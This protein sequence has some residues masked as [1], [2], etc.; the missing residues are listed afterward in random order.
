MFENEQYP[1]LWEV[2]ERTILESATGRIIF[3]VD[4]LDECAQESI[5]P[6][7]RSIKT[8]FNA[9]HGET[10][11]EK[12]KLAITS[13]H[14]PQTLIERLSDVACIEVSLDNNPES[15]RD[16]ERFIATN[17]D[18]LSLRKSLSEELRLQVEKELQKGA[19]GTFLWVGLMMKQLEAKQRIEM[20][21]AL[22]KLPS[23]LDSLYE[24]LLLQIQDANKPDAVAVVEYVSFV[25]ARLSFSELGYLIGQENVAGLTLDEVIADKIKFCEGLIEYDQDYIYPVHSSL[26]DYLAN[27]NTTQLSSFRMLGASTHT[28][29]VNICLS[30]IEEAMESEHIV[31]TYSKFVALSNE[32]DHGARLQKPEYK[33]MLSALSDKF[34][35]LAY[36]ERCWAYHG[37]L[38]GQDVYDLQRPLFNTDDTLR[39]RLSFYRYFPYTAGK[40]SEASF[41][42][43]TRFD[44]G[45]RVKTTLPL[46]HFALRWGAF[47]LVGKALTGGQD[48]TVQDSDGETIMHTFFCVCPVV[49]HGFAKPQLC[50]T[51][52]QLQR[53]GCYWDPEPFLETILGQTPPPDT[54]LG[55]QDVY[56]E[57]PIHKAITRGY[58]HVLKLIEK[59]SDSQT[60]LGKQGGRQRTPL[61]CLLD[62]ITDSGFFWVRTRDESRLWQSKHLPLLRAILGRMSVIDLS[63]KIDANGMTVLFYSVRHATDEIMELL[64]EYGAH[65]NVPVER[66][67]WSESRVDFFYNFNLPQVELVARDLFPANTNMTDA[68]TKFM[69][70]W[71]SCLEEAALRGD[72]SKVKLLIGYEASIFPEVDDH[73]SALHNAARTGRR[74]VAKYLLDLSTTEEVSSSVEYFGTPLTQAI[75]QSHF[76]I[77][78]LLLEKTTAESITTCHKGQ[79]ILHRAARAGQGWLVSLIA[80]K[81]PTD[82]LSDRDHE[83]F[84][85]LEL[86]IK[87]GDGESTRALYEAM[88]DTKRYYMGFDYL[89]RTPLHYAAETEN[90]D[91]IRFL[92]EQPALL[93]TFLKDGNG[94]T[95][96][97]RAAECGRMR[98]TKELLLYMR[99]DEVRIKDVGGDTAATLAEH[100]GYP[101]IADKIRGFLDDSTKNQ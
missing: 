96:L 101:G 70:M 87:F 18:D 77:A 31:Q 98:S 48:V 4:A 97:H 72:I 92:C 65:P 100:A 62:H 21:E 89:H 67:V 20:A 49:D 94:Q 54:I 15:L 47:P 30:H 27:C 50:T 16:V 34:P 29:L 26:R 9:N 37:I 90:L 41:F 93:D 53:P 17:V 11:R 51:S 12:F 23:G 86:A 76:I 5:D 82:R 79:N 61:H 85:A 68:G 73:P 75:L 7:L 13:R 40:V 6:F 14:Y 71:V 25:H 45:W 88:P 59:L 91:T 2:F 58:P 81:I 3:V 66:P 74:D 24:R 28:K 32:S 99:D 60:I 69:P 44:Q 64:L 19:E 10:F 8:S 35:F 1:M 95:P 52:D 80:S 43:F 33:V 22:K 55:A 42:R 36:A 56:G 39:T 63:N 46:I 57:T 83:G 38:S 84:S 78:M